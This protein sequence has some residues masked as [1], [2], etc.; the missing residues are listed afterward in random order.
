MD[1]P[2]SRYVCTFLQAVSGRGSR[3]VRPRLAAC[4]GEADTQGGGTRGDGGVHS[5]RSA[6]GQEVRSLR[7]DRAFRNQL[8]ASG[9]E[10]TLTEGGGGGLAELAWTEGWLGRGEPL[11]PCPRTWASTTDSG[12]RQREV[13]IGPC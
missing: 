2:P 6:R 9:L 8:S 5:Q 4:Q 3:G 12:T 1:R 11:L 10:D 7:R 13:C